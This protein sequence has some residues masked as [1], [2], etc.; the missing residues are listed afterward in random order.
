MADA[1]FSEPS[2]PDTTL[3]GLSRSAEGSQEV[4]SHFALTHMQ[5]AQLHRLRNLHLS[6]TVLVPAF[7]RGHAHVASHD[8]QPS[9]A[10]VGG[11]EPPCT[12]RNP[13]TAAFCSQ[14]CI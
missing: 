1:T 14:V 3:C 13:C 8:V 4:Q 2:A 6:R 9:A 7:S 12:V 11:E 10:A 5:E